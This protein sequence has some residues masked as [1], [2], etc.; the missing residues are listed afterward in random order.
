MF[1]NV[2]CQTVFDEDFYRIVGALNML[3]LSA[4][5]SAMLASNDEDTDQ[6]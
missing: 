6:D 3:D 4:F 5:G 1:I 2:M